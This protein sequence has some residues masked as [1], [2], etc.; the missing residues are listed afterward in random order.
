MPR[1]PTLFHYRGVDPNNPPAAPA[2][3]PVDLPDYRRLAE[4][5][6][7]PLAWGYIRGAAGDELTDS[8]NRTAYE[9]IKLRPRVMVDVS[10]LDTSVSLFGTR[11]PFPILLAP[12]A[13]QKLVHPEGEIAAAKGANLAQATLVVSAHANTAMEEVAAATDG[14]L[15]FQLYFQPDRAFTKGMVQRAQAAGYRALVVTV[16][17][18]VLGMRYR[19]KRTN[20]TLPSHLER[21]NLRGLAAAKGAQRA[22][23]D[24][25]YSATQDPTLTWKDLGWLRSITSL[26][27]LLKGILTP[28]DAEQAVASGASGIIVSNH[29]GRNLDTLPSTIE[30]L[31]AVAERVAGR[32]PVLV[33]GG[34]QRGTDVLKALGYGANAVLIGR[35]YVYGLAVNGAAGVADVVRILRREFE[36]AMALCGRSSI[37]EID[38]SV[39]W[40]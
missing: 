13:Y 6:M 37:A 12:T 5:K 23:D 20:F 4:S 2:E 14:P 11:M 29:G 8:W 39:I 38:R 36:A 21:P 24:T 40:G 17:A 25:I 31:P 1:P 28:E 35:P 22:G 26:P 15:W 30:A 19:E 32:V 16:D 9:R 18:P 7:T 33:D 34:I 3:R 10:K 27:I